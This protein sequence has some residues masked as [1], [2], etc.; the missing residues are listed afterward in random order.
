VLRFSRLDIVH[1]A[2]ADLAPPLQDVDGITVASLTDLR[3]AKLTCLLR[4]RPED[5]LALALRKDAGIDPGVLS[6]LL[7][8]FPTSPLPMMVSAL[9]V[10]EL[11]EY[12]DQLA[13]RFR[14]LAIPND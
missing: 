4:F 3:A 10:E 11:R 6:W 9:S 8:Q 12:R 1:E 5:D 7:N 13:E 2:A 14:R